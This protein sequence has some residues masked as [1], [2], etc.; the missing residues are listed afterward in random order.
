MGG[1]QTAAETLRHEPSTASARSTQNGILT[2]SRF[3]G[4]RAAPRSSGTPEPVLL[5][6]LSDLSPVPSFK[7]QRPVEEIVASKT[8]PPTDKMAE[9]LRT[10]AATG[11]KAGLAEN[12]IGR[13]QRYPPSPEGTRHE[14]RRR[15]D[16]P[17]RSS[18]MSSSQETGKS[19]AEGPDAL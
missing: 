14:K 15:F 5:A 4:L 10:L 13:K 3:R 16:L 2:R 7:R 12:A 17:V 18:E 9:E 1:S 8:P 11:E 6:G 19:E